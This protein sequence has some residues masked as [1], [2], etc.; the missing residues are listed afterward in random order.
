VSLENKE[1]TLKKSFA[2]KIDEKVK[3]ESIK[4]KSNL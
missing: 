3:K 4:E 1:E 2:R